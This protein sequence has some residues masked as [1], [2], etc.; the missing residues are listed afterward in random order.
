MGEPMNGP[1]NHNVVR[2]TRAGP[3]GGIS[4]SG[5]MGIAV[6]GRA[7]ARRRLRTSVRDLRLRRGLSTTTVS[8]DLGL[9]PDLLPA[10]ERGERGLLPDLLG[11]LLTCY[12]APTG[13]E[14]D[15]LTALARLA[16]TPHWTDTYRH[17][18]PR[19]Y[20][21]MLS[22]ETDATRILCYHPR[23]LPALAQTDAYAR[24]IIQATAGHH[25]SR[26]D[27]NARV[28]SQQRRQRTVLDTGRPLR[29]AVT[30]QAL[31]R[32]AVHHPRVIR[33]QLDH[34]TILIRAAR[35]DLTLIPTDHPRHGRTGPFELVEFDDPRDPDLV[36]RDN[37]AAGDALTDTPRTVNHYR[38]AFA[39]LT[40][41]QALSRLHDIRE[42]TR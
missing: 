10:I 38:T 32:P 40:H 25:L 9:P 26:D 4:G 15:Q 34:L 20:R 2:T 41:R 24:T 3:V 22:Y 31:L 42:R 27:I 16:Q 13:D 19:P 30:E 12:Q 21:E 29:I 33:Q 37:T 28:R 36:Y 17:I 7:V 8:R 1:G 11:R 5:G 14:V 6:V 18:H 23:H 39:D 35:I